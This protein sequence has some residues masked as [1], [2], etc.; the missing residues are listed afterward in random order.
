MVA[1]ARIV[2]L[3]GVIFTP[4]DV[5]PEAPTFMPPPQPDHRHIANDKTTM[6]VNFTREDCF[7]PSISVPLCRESARNENFVRR[8]EFGTSQVFEWLVKHSE[9]LSAGEDHRGSIPGVVP[10]R[11][12]NSY[13]EAIVGRVLPANHS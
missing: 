10:I 6:P 2:L 1:P 8:M 12:A 11:N 4:L 13:S 7:D 9:R 5:A 3:V